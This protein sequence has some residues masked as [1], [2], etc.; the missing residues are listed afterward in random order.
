MVAATAKCGSLLTSRNSLFFA[1]ISALLLRHCGLQLRSAV[2]VK[3][4]LESVIIPSVWR[5]L[6]LPPKQ[7]GQLLSALKKAR[8]VILF[9]FAL[10]ILQPLM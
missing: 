5:V 3:S 10:V 6:V 8:T 7:Q 9:R 1:L 2:L 4:K